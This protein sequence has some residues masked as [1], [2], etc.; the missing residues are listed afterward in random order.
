FLI[1]YLLLSLLRSSLTLF[2]YTT[3]FRSCLNRCHCP[4]HNYATVSFCSCDVVSIAS[5]SCCRCYF[6]R[7]LSRWHSIECYDVFSKRKCGSV[8]DDYGCIY[9]VGTDRNTCFNIFVCLYMASGVC[10]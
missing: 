10:R 8:S 7:L 4:V 6:S 9:R 3:L 2:P 1:F 5:G